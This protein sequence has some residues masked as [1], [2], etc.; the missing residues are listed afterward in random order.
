MKYAFAAIVG[1]AAVASALIAPAVAQSTFNKSSNGVAAKV[2]A[3]PS[4]EAAALAQTR[5]VELIKQ[6]SAFDRSIAGYNA[7]ARELEGKAKA[8]PQNAS[9]TRGSEKC[10]NQAEQLQA[11]QQNGAEHLA[12][13]DNIAESVKLCPSSMAEKL[14]AAQIAIKK[15]HE[16]IE[17]V[18]I[19]TEGSLASFCK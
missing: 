18:A 17:R 6:Q 14:T 7:K 16:V 4:Q 1:A 3:T 8:L 15:S 9:L 10:K 11:L 19:A 5:C 13:L 12:Y 2:Q